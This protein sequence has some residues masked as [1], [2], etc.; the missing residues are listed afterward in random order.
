VFSTPAV[1]NG[2]LSKRKVSKDTLSDSPL[3]EVERGLGGKVS[4]TTDDVQSIRQTLWQLLGEM[5][6]LFTP[7]ARLIERYE[8]G[9]VVVEKLTFDNGAGETVYG[10]LLLPP[11]L[12]AP[13]PAIHYLHGHGHKYHIGKEDVF[14]SG[15]IG[16][17]PGVE[18][19]K[20][21]YV[22]FAIDSYCFGERMGRAPLGMGEDGAATEQAWFKHFVW[23]GST[24]WGMMVRDDLLALNYLLS[25]PEV[26]ASRVGVT[27]M[28]MGGSRTTWLAALDERPRAIVPVAQ[29]TRYRDF[30]DTGRYNLHGIYYYLP[31]FLKSGLD[32]EHLVAL[33]APRPQL[34]LLG[35]EDPLSPVAGVRK[36]AD[37][38]RPIYEG[39]GAAEQFVLS[40]E[41]GVAHKYTREM[42]G[43]MVRFMDKY[44]KTKKEN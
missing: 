28:S 17:Q 36:V 41:A 21:G 34:I 1:L 10:Y 33:A 43:K 42:F 15:L 31:S 35:D 2:R 3:Y 20:A 12:S 5:P 27:G 19:V 24:L 11:D 6:P 4:L 30:A 40:L 8:R 37:F 9:G 7:E 39:Y 23:Q 22:V 18:L 44:L 16:L 38:A 29:M 32:M 25:R 13:A 14:L 26:D